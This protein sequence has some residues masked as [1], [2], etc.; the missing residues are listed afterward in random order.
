MPQIDNIVEATC[1]IGCTW[2]EVAYLT[3]GLVVLGAA[4]WFVVMVGGR[5]L[6][7]MVGSVLDLVVLLSW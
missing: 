6:T 7:R 5:L 3:E 1:Y 2:V 4:L